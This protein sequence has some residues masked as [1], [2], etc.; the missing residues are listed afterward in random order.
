M[1]SLPKIDNKTK[2]HSESSKEAQMN[3]GQ[4]LKSSLNYY[5]HPKMPVFEKKKNRS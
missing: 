2:W 1:F 5:F 4:K 3:V